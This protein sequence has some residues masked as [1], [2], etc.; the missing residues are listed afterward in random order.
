MFDSTPQVISPPICGSPSNCAWLKSEPVVCDP[1][2]VPLGL[3]EPAVV[4]PP[5]SLLHAAMTK[6]VSVSDRA[7]NRRTDGRSMVCLLM[8]IGVIWVTLPDP[9]T[10]LCRAAAKGLV[11]GAPYDSCLM[12]SLFDAARGRTQ[13]TPP[14]ES[15]LQRLVA[16][17]GLLADFCFSDLLLFV[18]TDGDGGTF[19]VLGQIRPTTSQTLYRHDLLG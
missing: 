6:S 13:L 16:S 14:Q 10:T 18:P 15:H 11:S 7:S 3:V 2:V 17:W 1:S 4:P 12:A 8:G 19:V 5:L 9:A